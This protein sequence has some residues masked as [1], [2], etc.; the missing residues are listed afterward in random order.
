[1]IIQGKHDLQVP[2]EEAEML[3]KAKPDAK[4][5]LVESMN[6]VLKIAPSDPESNFQAYADP[7]LPLA[8][9]FVDAVSKFLDENMKKKK[10]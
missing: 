7:N 4:K 6:H 8:Q 5:V 9:G 2:T 3:A 1:M 10:K